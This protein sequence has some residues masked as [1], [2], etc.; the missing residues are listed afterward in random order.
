M[1]EI[2]FTDSQYLR[3]PHKTLSSLLKNGP[4]VSV[5]IPKIGKALLATSNEAIIDLLKSPHRFTTDAT[6]VGKSPI[7]AKAGGMPDWKPSNGSLF[8][9]EGNQHRTIRHQLDMALRKSG[10]KT[11]RP[12]IAALAD[13]LISNA[14]PAKGFP[15]GHID[16][17]SQFSRPLP[18][19]VMME[20]MGIPKTDA[21][22]ILKLTTQISYPEGP[23]GGINQQ[24]A[25]KKLFA[26]LKDLL[27]SDELPQDSLCFQ[28]KQQPDTTAEINPDELAHLAYFLLQAGHS[29]TSNLIALGCMSL[30]DHPTQLKTLTQDWTKAP[31]AVEEILRYAAPTQMTAPRYAKE[32]F[33]FYDHTFKRGDIVFGFLAATNMDSSSTPNPDIFDISR[34]PIRHISFGAGAHF[35]G[36]AQLAHLIAEIALQRLFTHRPELQHASNLT[37]SIIWLPRFGSRHLSRFIVNTTPSPARF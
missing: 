11:L 28:L 36:G 30:L 27:A 13:T 3:S 34:S 35:C 2:D 29:T 32:T 14:I 9:A 7:C 37:K 5:K 12:N 4:L 8:L 23:L 21:P 6:Q 26:Y 17:V 31:N 16:L 24:S 33:T 20:L 18:A 19:L 15:T 1:S 10:I 22:D 25:G